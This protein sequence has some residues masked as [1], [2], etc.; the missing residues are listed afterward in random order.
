MEL[1]IVHDFLSQRGGAERVVLRLARLY[2]EAPIFTSFYD[3]EATF[4]EFRR[5]CVVTSDLQD[6]VSPDRFRRSVLRYGGAFGR[7]D[8][9][10]A[11]TVVISSSGF[12]HHVRHPHSIVYCHTPPRYLWAPASYAPRRVERLVQATA[13]TV[14]APARHLDRRAARRHR[15]YVANSEGTRRRVWDAYRIDAAVVHPPLWLG[16]LPAK[17][18]P[19]PAEPRALLVSRLLPYKRVDLAI[20]AC[21]QAQV[22]LTVVGAG[23]ELPRLQA[24]AGSHV[25]WIGSCDDRQLAELFDAHSLVVVPGRED[26]GYLPVEAC[27]AGRPVVAAAEAGGG[28]SMVDGITGRLVHGDDPAIWARAVS[29]VAAGSWD[30]VALRASVERFAPERFDDAITTLVDDMRRNR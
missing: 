17:V 15:R 12:A 28:E 27:Y 16:H 13:P 11:E 8:L 9:A 25:R 10:D 22:P 26:F 20:A 29:E 19:L 1:A 21:R 3:P 30:P 24:L 18:S 4:P 2:P 6:R 5:R 14:L 23:P 7:M